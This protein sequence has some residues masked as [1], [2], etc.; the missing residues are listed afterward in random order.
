[1]TFLVRLCLWIE[2][3]TAWPGRAA[4]WLLPLLVVAVCLS[5]AAASLRINVFLRWSDPVPLF[6]RS[7]TVNGML[8]LHWHLFTILVML[9]GAF[10]LRT[11]AHVHVDFM[12]ARFRPETQKVITILGDIFL[13]LPFCL[14]MTWYGW[15]FTVT[16]FNMGEGSTYGGLADRYL[17][18]AFLPLGFALLALNA[19]AR[20]LRLVAEL[21]SPAAARL[22]REIDPEAGRA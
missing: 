7:L 10:A 5:V 1:M 6:G 9:G 17:I 18:K 8:D 21:V 11:N 16:S 20:M 4:G 14:F 12:S 22:S 19:T 2:R 3:I 13:L 15:R